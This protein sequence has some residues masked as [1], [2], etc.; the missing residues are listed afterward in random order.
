MLRGGVLAGVIETIIADTLGNIEDVALAE[1]TI[2]IGGVLQGFINGNPEKPALIIKAR[3]KKGAK[4]SHVKL[5][6]DVKLDDGVEMGEG[7]EYENTTFEDL[8]TNQD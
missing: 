6:R 4:L 5:G 7:V 1:N 2:L 8:E 3:I